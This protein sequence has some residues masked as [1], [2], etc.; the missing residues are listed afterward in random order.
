[1]HSAAGLDVEK[2]LG[3]IDRFTI[4]NPFFS[5]F[6]RLL[7]ISPCMEL[8]SPRIGPS[9]QRRFRSLL[10][11]AYHLLLFVFTATN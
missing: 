10:R 6:L 8:T 3:S 4:H 9:E 7:M 5:F 11:Y 1:M 2:L